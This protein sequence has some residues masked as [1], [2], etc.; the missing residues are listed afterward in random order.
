MK[1]KIIHPKLG[2]LVKFKLKQPDEA[3]ATGVL[4]KIFRV[5]NKNRF[6]YEIKIIED[7][8]K[9]FKGEFICIFPD[10]II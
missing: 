7:Q 2:N 9:F 6:V 8:G 10:E 1:E 4:K 5:K 3:V